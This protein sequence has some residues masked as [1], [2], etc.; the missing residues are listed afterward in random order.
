VRGLCL[1]RAFKLDGDLSRS[2]TM[3]PLIEGGSIEGLVA[4][5]SADSDFVTALGA[6][7]AE[8][9]GACL[10][11]HAGQE[12]VGLGAVAAVGLKGTLRHDKKLLRRRKLLL[13][14]FRL[15]QQSLSIPEWTGFSQP[16]IVA[17]HV[18]R[19]IVGLSRKR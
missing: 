10:C 9:S 5:A 4:K 18:R 1:S 14:L 12:T 16:V 11:L 3:P 2:G 13:K 15:L 7:A 19:E 6:T 17:E 8:D